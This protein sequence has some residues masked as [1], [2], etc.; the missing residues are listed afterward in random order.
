MLILIY[1]SFFFF[2][3]VL[4]C[5]LGLL[6]PQLSNKSGMGAYECNEQPQQSLQ[7]GLKSSQQPYYHHQDSGRKSSE[8]MPPKRV[9]SSMGGS[10]TGNSTHESECSDENNSGSSPI[11]S[12]RSTQMHNAGTS[13]HHHPR[14]YYQPTSAINNV[15]HP[16]TNNT[17]VN[18]NTELFDSLAA[19]LRA[20][21]RGD[22]PPLLLPP[23]DYDTVHRSKGN[24]TAIELRRCRNAL[25]VGNGGP[26]TSAAATTTAQSVAAAAAAAAIKGN[27]QSNSSANVNAGNT[28]NELGVVGGSTGN[29]GGGK[30]ISSRGSSGIGSDLAPSPERHE[31][32]SS[33]GKSRTPPQSMLHII[34][35]KITINPL[36]LHSPN[37][38]F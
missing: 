9:G 23:R 25:I 24:L 35:S 13:N 6:P 27:N 5:R 19:E 22:G 29:S 38:T 15:H 21:L 33:S 18:A 1:F 30:L 12:T 11:I 26:K 20:K 28:P 3:C 32:N 37:D 36:S 7:N 34:N 10:D 16:T 14:N 8:L 31:T 2:L 17:N 4:F